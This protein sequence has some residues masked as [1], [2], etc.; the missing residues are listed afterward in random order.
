MRISMTWEQLQCDLVSK[1][2]LIGK[3]R[4]QLLEGLVAGF[5]CMRILANSGIGTEEEKRDV[6]EEE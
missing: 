4:L 5:G 1:V 2:I 3:I 6:A